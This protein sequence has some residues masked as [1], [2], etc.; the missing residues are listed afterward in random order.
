VKGFT[1]VE[2]IPVLGGRAAMR[3]IPLMA[4]LATVLAACGGGEKKASEQTTTTTP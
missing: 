1:K 4:A 2:N 3:V